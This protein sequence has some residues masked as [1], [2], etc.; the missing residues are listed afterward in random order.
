MFWS[1]EKIEVYVCMYVT[2]DLNGLLRFLFL[3]SSPFP[4][5]RIYESPRLVVLPLQFHLL[6]G[7]AP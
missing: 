1:F 2:L 4:K 6:L 7:S 5:W 3:L